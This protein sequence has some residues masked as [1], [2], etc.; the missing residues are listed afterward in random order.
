YPDGRKIVA[1]GECEGH[2]I[3]EE[4]GTGGFGYDT[5]FIPEGYDKTFGEL[6]GELKNKISHRA[7]ALVELERLLLCQNVDY[8]K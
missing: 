2:I 4:R 8:Y 6:P 7:K 1:R 3:F 5:L